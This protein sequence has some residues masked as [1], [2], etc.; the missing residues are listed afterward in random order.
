MGGLVPCKGSPERKAGER[1]SEL[2]LKF[3]GCSMY[4]SSQSL[5]P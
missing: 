4:G 1:D 2:F 5:S 3:W